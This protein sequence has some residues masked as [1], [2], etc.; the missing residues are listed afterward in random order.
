[1]KKIHIT[2]WVGEKYVA[3]LLRLPTEI[4]GL[5]SKA[6]AIEYSIKKAFPKEFADEP[7]GGYFRNSK[8]EDDKNDNTISK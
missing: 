5:R 1:M 2:A 6:S 3:K 7:V 8:Q 4:P